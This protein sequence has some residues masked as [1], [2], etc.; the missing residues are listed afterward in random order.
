M[1]RERDALEAAAWAAAEA[2]GLPVLGICR[3][4]QAMNV[5]AGGPLRQHVDGHAGPAGARRRR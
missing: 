4:F 5:F 1:E 3:G 2:R